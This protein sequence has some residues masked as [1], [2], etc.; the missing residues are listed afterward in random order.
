[1]K[2][3][4]LLTIVSLSLITSTRPADNK[5]FFNSRFL[6]LFATEMAPI[7]GI[8]K[9]ADRPSKNSVAYLFMHLIEKKLSS[10]K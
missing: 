6:R 4:I 2:K 8:Y 9:K 10:R 7:E 3:M 5:S 1:M